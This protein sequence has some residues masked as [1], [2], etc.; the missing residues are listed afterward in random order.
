M[1]RPKRLSLRCVVVRHVARCPAA[2]AARGVGR[3]LARPAPRA[4][5]HR[6]RPSRTR[7]ASSRTA[8]NLAHHLRR[9]RPFAAR[10]RSAQ[11]WQ[12]DSPD[13]RALKTTPATSFHRR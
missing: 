12:A 11:R 8:V 9:S 6:P 13:S 5:A 1:T 7:A 10:V 3:A 4:R 2:A